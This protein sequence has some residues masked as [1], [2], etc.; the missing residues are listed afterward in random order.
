LKN[1]FARW[2]TSRDPAPEAT[3]LAMDRRRKRSFVAARVLAGSAAIGLLATTASAGGTKDLEQSEVYLND[4]S[5]HFGQLEHD[6]RQVARDFCA[7]LGG[8]DQLEPFAQSEEIIRENEFSKKYRCTVR[9]RVE[10]YE[11]E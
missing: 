5:S 9:S 6:A 4:C 1:G 8:I 3:G 10:C 11:D 7:E 2:S